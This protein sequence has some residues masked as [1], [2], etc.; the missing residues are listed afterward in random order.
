MRLPAALAALVVLAAGASAVVLPA[1]QPT[2]QAP[3][4]SSDASASHT[5]GGHDHGTHAHGPGEP[6]PPAAPSAHPSPAHAS[7][8]HGGWSG[9]APGSRDTYAWSPP[10]GAVPD[11]DDPGL[12]RLRSLDARTDR[13]L[14]ELAA[15]GW[16]QGRGTREAPYLIEGLRVARDL[17]IADTAAHV[18]VRNNAVLGQ[19]TLNWNG[20]A[21]HVHHNRITDLRV[22]E[23]VAR[24][25]DVTGGLVER[26]VIGFVGQLRHYSGEFR[27]N[28]IGP[29]PAG[30]FEAALGDSGLEVVP[31]QE[32]WNFDGFHGA[33]VHHN[34]VQGLVDIK[35][36]GHHHGSAFDALPHEH[37]S[38]H[39]QAHGVDHQ[40]RFHALGFHHNTITVQEGPALVYRDTPHAGDD[41]TA[42]SE[43][44]PELELPH[45]HRTSVALED[46]R[47]TGGGLVV[48]VFSS[49]DERHVGGDA[50][51]LRIVRNVLTFH[52]P[53]GPVPGAPLLAVRRGGV[54]LDLHDAQGV[55]LVVE[56]NTVHFPAP[57]KGLVGGKAEGIG[58]LL[59]GWSG[60]ALEVVANEVKGAGTGLRARAFDEATHWRLAG[61]AFD[62]PVQVDYDASVANQPT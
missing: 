37:A 32:V 62:A 31:E 20:Q 28:R 60:S 6:H 45:V 27:E 24:E 26:N 34:V 42:A 19:L 38:S 59:R 23:N 2:A 56:G 8:G 4:H 47:L 41:R 29:K 5:H 53:E 21:I 15:Q 9:A 33:D 11:A 46:N 48:R 58:I 1:T 10:E 52:A 40:V 13:G 7:S 44:N 36:H 25:G 16:I 55:A 50:G 51:T 14:A 61:N 22:N 43:T 17:T 35:L 57:G 12:R 49:Q 54:G 39:G 3:D 18:I 30:P